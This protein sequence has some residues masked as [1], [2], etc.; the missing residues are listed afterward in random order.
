MDVPHKMFLGCFR[1]FLGQKNKHMSN[2]TKNLDQ[3]M[4]ILSMF[5]LR[6]Y[7]SKF[8]RK[9]IYKALYLIFNSCS[10]EITLRKSSTNIINMSKITLKSVHCSGHRDSGY[11][12]CG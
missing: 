2:L 11:S 8:M 3:K 9:N 6:C 12:R 10:F 7:L 5:C 1:W 4:D